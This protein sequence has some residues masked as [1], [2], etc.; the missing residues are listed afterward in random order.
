[1][2]KNFPSGE[3]WRKVGNEITEAVRE[4]FSCKKNHS[5]LDVIIKAWE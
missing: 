2:D 1:M 5:L 3:R 4:G